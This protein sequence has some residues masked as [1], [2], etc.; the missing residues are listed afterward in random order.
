MPIS[1]LKIDRSFVVEIPEEGEPDDSS[2]TAIPRAIIQL[3]AEFNLSVVA[4]GVETENQKN[5]LLKNGCDVIQGFLFSRP[6]SADEFAAL[7]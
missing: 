1:E 5:F 2:R 3:A 6:V 4:E 7:L